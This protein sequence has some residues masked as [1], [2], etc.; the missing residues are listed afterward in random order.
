MR[1][2]LA[3]VLLAGCLDQTQAA[4]ARHLVAVEAQA[5]KLD[6]LA[7]EPFWQAAESTAPFVYLGTDL[8]AD[9][10]TRGRVACDQTSLYLYL[11][12]DEPDLDKLDP[13]AYAHDAEDLWR[14]HG[15]EVLLAPEIGGPTY[16]HF[17][18]TFGGGRY[19]AL[20]GGDAV[21]TAWDPQP[22]W[23][24]AVAK[25]QGKVTAELAIPFAALG[26]SR[27][28]RGEL[29]GL[30]LCR[31]LWGPGGQQARDRFTV[32]A[33]ARSG[34]HDVAGWGR[35]YFGGLNALDN[36]EFDDPPGA[37]R[38]PHGWAK[39]LTW[40]QGD[41]ATGDVTQEEVAGRQVIR[42]VKL[43][44]A[45]G[46]LLPRF[47]RTVPVRA[48]HRYRFTAVVQAR[49]VVEL[50]FSMRKGTSSIYLP[51]P[52]ELP[53]GEFR[54]LAADSDVPD[55]V[56]AATLLISF[57]RATT[58]ELLID[59]VS[60]TD[61][62]PAPRP[63]GQ[64][65]DLLHNLRA[66]A[67]TV[68]EMKPYDKVRDADGNYPYERL[69][70]HDTGTGAELRRITWDW[71]EAS[72]S[73][74]NMYPWNRTGSAFKFDCWSR[75][76]PLSFIAEP[77]GASFRRLGLETGAPRWGGDPARPDQLYYAT[78]DSLHQF[79]WRTGEDVELYRIPDSMRHGGRGSIAWNLDKPGL[80]YH[81]Q[82]F[83]LDAPLYYVD[84]A[85]KQ[86]TRL[87]LTSDS[88]GDR[89]K[90]WLYSAGL[91]QIDGKWWVGYSL[92]HLP[93]LSKDNPYQQR[94][95]S[96]DGKVGLDRLALA[97]PRGKGPQPLYS[98]GG[99]APNGRWECGYYGGGISLWDFQTWSG[100]VL[101]PGPPG[102]HIS[103]MYRN[104]FFVA[105]TLGEPLGGPF[106][107]QIIKVY[108]DGTW[109]RVA[110]GNTTSLEYYDDFF[111]NLSPDGTKCAWQ[112]SMLGPVNL[113]WCVMAQP[114]PPDELR[115]EWQGS[116]VRL[117]WRR[118][119]HSSEL[120]GYRVYRGERSGVG[121]LR[122]TEP[123]ITA[124]EYLETV[125][126]PARSWYYC[127]TS[128][129]HSGLESWRGAEV[130]AGDPGREPERLFV[131]A[132]QG[133]LRPPL[134]EAF[135]G[136]AADLRTIEYRPG[137]GGAGT[138]A[139]TF[140]TRRGGEHVLWVRARYVGAGT[141]GGG[142]SFTVAGRLLGEVV[143][144]G[145]EWGW[146]K[147]PASVTAK[148]G[149]TTIELAAA[150][151]GLA[152]DKLLL[153]DDLEFQPAGRC[154][155]DEQPPATPAGLKLDEARSFD[156]TLSWDPVAADR[157]HYQVYRGT[158]PEFKA[159]QA[160][161]VGSPAVA[162]FVEWG[163]RQGTA[164]FYRVAAVDSFG[165][166]SPPSAALAV[167]TVALP[168][169]VSLRLEAEAGRTSRPMVVV[170]DQAASGGKY[171]KMAPEQGDDPAGFPTLSLPFAAPV[172]G[173]YVAWV[174]LCPVSGRGYAY[175]TAG[176]DD[177]RRGTF[178]CRFPTRTPGLDFRYTN[179]WH[180]VDAMREELPL[181]FKLE[182]GPHI[183]TISQ[184]HLQEFG[185]DEA[186]ITNDLGTRPTGRHH[187]WAS[188]TGSGLDS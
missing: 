130:V 54:T 56:T 140:A 49:G 122:L 87:P 156:V 31:S 86:I 58:G 147:L 94:L 172:A 11:E 114:D 152:I 57:D 176:I 41:A 188:A 40:G 93:H 64:G 184:A 106:D 89:A 43:P 129:E 52:T 62:G 67:E 63:A 18:F 160:T 23:Q 9:K 3:V 159:E 4:E 12:A 169:L 32:W 165:N 88:P 99:S 70:F 50:I 95:V 145:R 97:Q 73:Y 53:G 179:L 108:T 84:L 59:S 35:L 21:P 7:D 20:N 109:Y 124:N 98:H 174:R 123:P 69:I 120:A 37:N 182:P 111:V 82:A 30:K 91:R 166:E 148:P 171:V 116:R 46:S 183:L 8:P 51:N 178:L 118:P 163:L 162:R 141:P 144:A 103:W 74:S 126:D 158:T 17:I 161:L 39:T 113:F 27:P 149:G 77:D 1:R 44:E 90:D 185:L 25:G 135:D 115:A 79:N 60:L 143:A 2:F 117:T 66:V 28:L 134:R 47:H 5:A 170:E 187:R 38:L 104:D 48:G 175:L 112:S 19:D 155:V 180:T 92:N 137:D 186:L 101:V 164:Y 142:W 72:L 150:E 173:D 168:R 107:A 181:R 45:K 125:P 26:A 42:L 121:Y 136:T 154:R 133:V 24:V 100:K 131:E 151:A 16:Y 139:W 36:P 34:Y 110:Y 75:P 105:G 65:V 33:P 138:A 61:L 15:I 78:R 85:T 22:D 80:V 119:E 167:T 157:D 177:G 102:G 127:V 29:W 128:V 76:G 146:S 13:P 10:Q 83:G 132:E 14:G 68:V 71:N 81:E 96:L 153:T 6:G 55:Q